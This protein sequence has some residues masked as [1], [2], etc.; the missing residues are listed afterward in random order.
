M[1]PSFRHRPDGAPPGGALHLSHRGTEIG[2]LAPL[3]GRDGG[4]PSRLGQLGG[5]PPGGAPHQLV[6]LAFR[7]RRL[8]PL[9]DVQQQLTSHRG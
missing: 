1:A 8:D 6:E 4:H 9:G 2:R 3:D 7:Q 5:G